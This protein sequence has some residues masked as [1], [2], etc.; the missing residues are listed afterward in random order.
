MIR[1]ARCFG[2]PGAPPWPCH[3]WRWSWG[4]CL[5]RPPLSNAL[6]RSLPNLPSAVMPRTSPSWIGRRPRFQRPGPTRPRPRASFA[7]SH[8]SLG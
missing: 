7:S 3:A 1:L 4:Q 5:L 2:L 8:W 6:P